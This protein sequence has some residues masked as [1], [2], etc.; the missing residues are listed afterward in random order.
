MTNTSTDS[1]TKPQPVA[2]SYRIQ[3][4]LTG[5]STALVGAGAL[6][7]NEIV[8]WAAF[9]VSVVA[10]GWAG[11]N[12]TS[13]GVASQVVPN[14][15]VAAYRAAGGALVAGPAADV[16]LGTP[17]EQPVAQATATDDPAGPGQP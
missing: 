14:S 11:Y 17:V 3:A 9:I 8:T 10:A 15:D 2:K 7:Q 12:G 1:Y 4:A 5:V 16:G 13:S 6:S